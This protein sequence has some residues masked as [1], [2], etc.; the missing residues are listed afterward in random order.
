MFFH[1]FPVIL[2]RILPQ[3]LRTAQ[4]SIK[5]S[6]CQPRSIQPLQYRTFTQSN[7]P[8]INQS[9]MSVVPPVVKRYNKLIPK[10]TSWQPDATT[11]S[12][13]DQHAELVKQSA[14]WPQPSPDLSVDQ[15]AEL[16]AILQTVEAFFRDVQVATGRGKGAA[17]EMTPEE[18]KA[19]RQA[20]NKVAKEKTDKSNAQGAKDK[21]ATKKDAPVVVAPLS[22]DE[23]RDQAQ[24]C[25]VWDRVSTAT[26][27]AARVAN[28]SIK[29]TL[30]NGKV[31]DATAGITTPYQIAKQISISKAEQWLIA[32]VNDSQWDMMRPLEGD[33]AIQ[34]FDFD[35]PEG[36]HTYWHS[37]AHILGQAVERVYGDKAKLCVGPALEDG[38]FYYD[39]SLG[40]EKLTPEVFPKLESLV[41][42]IIKEKQPFTRLVLKKEEALE[43]FKNNQYKQYIISTKVPDGETCTAYRCGPLIDLCRGPHVPNSSYVKALA[44]TKNSSSYW[45]GD[46]AN[47]S[48]QRVYGISF[49]SQAQLD[50]WME[51]QRQAEE[52]DHRRLGVAQHL[53]MFHD[54]SPGSAFMLP[55]GTR[56]YN[57]LVDFMR[58]EY[59]KRGYQEVIS[60]N[61]FNVDLW[62]TSGHYQNYK[63][64]MF[65][66]ECE[67]QEW[68]MKPMNV[69]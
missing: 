17:G 62:K 7:S 10:F 19:A 57:K 33:C 42:S 45:L 25:A 3:A 59:V 44:V 15:S 67:K 65:L 34:F 18:R 21:K 46:A 4:I 13:T 5:R 6:I 11:Q 2:V 1:A 41:G 49:P 66:F 31:L 27:Q 29:V 64:H 39:V 54:L 52:R 32:R 56:V 9:N 35:T 26:E 24:R 60:P 36:S 68:A 53:F 51:Q 58:S 12:L 14:S 16:E 61:V 48:L 50:T 28:Q 30:P 40:E 47:D 55:H 37:S 23:T 20:A 8:I 22:A 63:E 43:M 38:G 69:S